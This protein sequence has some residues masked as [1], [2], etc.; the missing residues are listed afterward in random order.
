MDAFTYITG[1]ATLLALV[2][3]LK[4]SFPTHRETRAFIVVLILG[5][6]LGSVSASIRGVSVD[7]GAMTPGYALIAL[8]AGITA[9]IAIVAAFAAEQIRRNELF[10]F[11]GLGV[12]ATLFTMALVGISGLDE[13][14]ARLERDQLTLD[15]LLSLSEAAA[16]KANYERAIQL[17]ESATRRLASS[18]PRFKALKERENVLRN[19]QVTSK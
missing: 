10:L 15:E 9:L 18:D 4:D 5:M 17:L 16:G 8:F 2:L 12:I 1:I 13:A 19:K 6:F 3:Q 7:L 11:A 14:R